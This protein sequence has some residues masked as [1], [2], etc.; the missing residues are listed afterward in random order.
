M[1]CP[2]VPLLA[3]L[4]LA[5]A[6]VVAVPPQEHPASSQSPSPWRRFTNALISNF[7]HLPAGQSPIRNDQDR[8]GRTDHGLVAAQ[9]GRDIVL[10]FNLTTA[11]EAQAISDAAADLYLDIWEFNQNWVDIRLA[12]DIVSL[13]QDIQYDQCEFRDLIILLASFAAQ[14]STII[15]QSLSRSIDS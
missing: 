2:S 1:R 7:W 3:L 4:C 6:A 14:P 11:E 9:Y 13:V 10:R 12:K 8:K 15:P 5:P